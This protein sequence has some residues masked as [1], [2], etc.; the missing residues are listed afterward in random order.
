MIF[1]ELDQNGSS[2]NQFDLRV[3]E[4]RRNC[5]KTTN[6]RKEK[7]SH[8]HWG[9]GSLDQLP[10]WWAGREAWVLIYRR[11]SLIIF[12]EL[13]KLVFFY[14]LLRHKSLVRLLCCIYSCFCVGSDVFKKKKKKNKNYFLGCGEE[15][16]LLISCSHLFLFAL[17]CGLQD[18]VL[19]PSSQKF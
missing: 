2:E 18:V 16:D 14:I 1:V 7:I 6:L 9:L 19:S 3:Q 10:G 5:M 13:Y 15:S 17:W 8:R 11:Q 12:L 4:H